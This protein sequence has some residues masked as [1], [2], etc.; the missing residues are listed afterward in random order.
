MLGEVGRRHGAD[1]CLHSGWPWRAGIAGVLAALCFSGSAYAI[2][3]TWNGRAPG[4]WTNGANWS[5]AQVPDGTATFS[6]AGTSAVTNAGGGV[7]IGTIQF[8][9][10]ATS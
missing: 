2:D 6:A 4:E 1:S 5:G 8:A 9:P 10:A 3:A 7:T